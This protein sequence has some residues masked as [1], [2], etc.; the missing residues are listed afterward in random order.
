MLAVTQGGGKKVN[1]RRV[2]WRSAL[3]LTAVAALGAC[4]SSSKS[5][6]SSPTTASTG[7]AGSASTSQAGSAPT[8]AAATGGPLKVGLICDCSGPFGSDIAAAGDVGKAWADSVNAAGGID[9]HMVTL[10]VLDD[11]SNPGT[12][13]SDVQT[14]ISDHVDVILDDSVLDAA[15]ASTV[16]AAKIPVVGGNFSSEPFFTNPDFYPSGQTNDSITYSNVAVAKQAGAT[17]IGNLYCAEAPQCQQSVPL[18]K[19]AGQQVGVPAV[20]NASIAM[21][22]PNYTAQCVAAKQQHVSAI[23]IGD[24]SA[25][26]ARVGSDCN[27]QGYDP[28]YITEGTGFS[29]Q[30]T[31][32][33]GLKNTLWSDY[34]ILPFWDNASEVQ[35]MN[36]A[37]DKYYPGLRSNNQEWSEY[38]A[39][40]WTAGLLIQDA[41]K[42]SGIGTSGTPSAA[43]M[44]Q[45]LNSIKGDTLDGWS[46]SLTFT[47]G[48]PH[49]V[50][51]W[52]VARMQGGTPSLVNGGQQTCQSG[53]T[54]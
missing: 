37:V 8:A 9:G 53:T 50:D 34:P 43:T 13:T 6:S 40:T 2:F 38:A 29:L 23:F 5:S 4:S 36:T 39:Q 20:Y 54:P 3:A 21:T 11:A 16:A 22:A 49:K 14:L 1:K 18:I 35:T 17:N 27:Q 10:T 45:G 32:T 51:C 12:S 33:P 7:Q 42:G 30:L 48:Q 28:I 25:T 44:T 52:F 24:S 15:W 19:A 47:A 46:P 31:S 26:I 41:V